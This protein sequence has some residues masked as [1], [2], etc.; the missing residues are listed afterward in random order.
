MVSG[1]GDLTHLSMN[2]FIKST[3][4]PPSFRVFAKDPVAERDMCG[5]GVISF[6]ERD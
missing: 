2:V 5:L 1:E 4:L 6:L 3:D